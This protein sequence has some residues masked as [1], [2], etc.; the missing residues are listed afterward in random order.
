MAEPK[1]RLILTRG[2]ETVFDNTAPEYLIP[3]EGEIIKS[4]VTNGQPLNRPVEYRV[5]KVTYDLE[6][7][8]KMIANVYAEAFTS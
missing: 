3:R 1:V 2:G 4:A 7:K 5:T 6:R 8:R